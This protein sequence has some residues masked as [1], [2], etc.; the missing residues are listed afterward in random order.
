M[1][2][3]N[4]LDVADGQR[5]Q[6]DIVLNAHFSQEQ[7]LASS[8]EAIEYLYKVETPGTSL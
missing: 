7:K 2:T 6:T 1:Y 3:I 4:F 8:S 5:T